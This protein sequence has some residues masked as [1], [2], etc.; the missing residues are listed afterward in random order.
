M[1]KYGREARAFADREQARIDS[2][3]YLAFLA[4]I[5]SWVGALLPHNSG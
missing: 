5:A 4:D 3:C 2:R 1:A